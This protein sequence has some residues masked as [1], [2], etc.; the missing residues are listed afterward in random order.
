MFILISVYFLFDRY[1]HVTE[2][3]VPDIMHDILEDILPFELKELLKFMISEKVTTLAELN[4]AIHSFP[5]TFVDVTNKPNII[6][7]ST[8]C[9]T[10]HSLKQ[11]S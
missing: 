3:L 8:L 11:T 7:A 5:Y 10:D 1:F 2:G 9:S 4:D 6:E